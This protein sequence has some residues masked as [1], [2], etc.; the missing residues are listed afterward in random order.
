VVDAIGATLPNA[1]A[2]AISPMPI[3]TVILLLMTPRSRVLGSAFLV[4][5]LLGVIVAV[6]VFSAL[7]DVVPERGSDGSQPVIGVIKLVIGV[8]LLLLSVRRRR[9]RPG[10]GE[11][12]SL[13]AW[14]S[15]IDTIGVPAAFAIAL[16][17]AAVS[18]KNLLASASAG[19]L[20]GRAGLD[21][22]GAVV[23]VAVFSVIAALT[24]LV[25]VLCALLAPGPA[26]SALAEVRTWLTANNAPIMAVL[27]VVLGAKVIGDGIASF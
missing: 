1:V 3:I 12:P 5:W 7:A 6:S 27:L 8:L 18:P 20:I 14:M 21:G 15:R 23:T 24:V 22:A 19:A 11:E 17:L 2:I 4:G 26:S 9:S 13:P 16:G 25:P 10:P